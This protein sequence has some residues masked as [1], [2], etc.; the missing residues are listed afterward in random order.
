MRITISEDK[1]DLGVQAA[2]LGASKILEAIEK[3]GSATI[4]LESGA[5][6]IETLK[7]LANYEN[8]PWNKVCVLQFD[9]FIGIDPNSPKSNTY[10]LQT[11]FLNILGETKVKC[12]HPLGTKETSVEE[13][14]KIAQDMD[15]DVAFSCIGENGHLGYNDPPAN[16][17]TKDAYIA[18]DLDLRSRKQLVGEKWFKKLEDVPTRAI[19]LSI[20]KLLSAR[21]IIVSCPDQRKARGVATCLYGQMNPLQPCTALRRKVECNLFLD[22]PSSM[23]ILGDNRPK[24]H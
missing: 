23:L 13:A 15:I 21:T 16:F 18:V 14:N 6:Q 9:E 8:I 10:F 17:E 20:R 22:K 4:V 7:N 19:T 1:K 12:F 24:Y 2:K 5:S 11:Q 3:K